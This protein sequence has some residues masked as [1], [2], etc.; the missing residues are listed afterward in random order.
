MEKIYTFIKRRRDPTFLLTKLRED[1]YQQNQHQNIQFCTKSSLHVFFTC[2][3]KYGAESRNIK[4]IIIE[5]YRKI[6]L[7][8]FNLR[9][10]KSVPS[11][12]SQYLQHLAEDLVYGK[13]TKQFTW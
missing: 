13:N 3:F 12:K 8:L 7:F 4:Y 1:E 10:A 2:H 6:I 11:V 5:N 9:K